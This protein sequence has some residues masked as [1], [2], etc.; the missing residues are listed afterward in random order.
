MMGEVGNK[1]AVGAGMNEED[2]KKILVDLIKNSIEEADRDKARERE[3]LVKRVEAAYWEAKRIEA[4]A[5]ASRNMLEDNRDRTITEME[6][7]ERVI[8]L[9]EVVEE[10]SSQLMTMFNL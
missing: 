1:T 8:S 5:W 7:R 2:K 4:V 6:L 9:L 10:K 3:D